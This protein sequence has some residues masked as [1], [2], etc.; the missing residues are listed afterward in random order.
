MEISRTSLILL[1]LP[2]LLTG[3]HMNVEISDL[4][5]NNPVA[6][7]DTKSTLAVSPSVQHSSDST[8]QYK[9]RSAVGEVTNGTSVSQDGL[10]HAE[11]SITYQRL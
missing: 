5:S 11:V 7:S 10:Y 8:N 3:C 9:A 6:S 2:A 4:T 1:M